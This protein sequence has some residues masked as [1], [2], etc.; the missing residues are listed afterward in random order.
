MAQRQ[1]VSAEKSRS[2]EPEGVSKRGRT[3]SPDR[4][5][6]KDPA[7]AARAVEDIRG[8]ALRRGLVPWRAVDVAPASETTANACE[9]G[10]VCGVVYNDTNDNVFLRRARQELPA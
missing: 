4:A 3:N 5:T 2:Q 9:S 10:G 6:G 1:V 8:A 7:I